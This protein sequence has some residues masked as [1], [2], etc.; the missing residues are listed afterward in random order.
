MSVF[1]AYDGSAGADWVSHYAVRLAARHPSAT[2]RLLHVQDR[3]IGDSDLSVAASRIQEEAARIGVACELS[4]HPL[5]RTVAETLLEVVPAGADSYLICGTRVRSHRSG[6]LTGT[7]S[8]QLLQ[9]GHCHTLAVRVHQ[10]GLL[11]LPRRLLLPVSGHPRG[12]RSG[13]PFLKLLQRDISHLQVLYIEQVGRWRFRSLTHEHAEQLRRPC[14]VYCARIERE[15]KDQLDLR[16][17]EIDTNVV[18]S[19]DAPKEI[20]IAA[21]KTKSRLI[22][23]GA[24]ERNLAQRLYFGDL[25]EHVLH[26]ATCDVA[27]YRGIG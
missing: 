12:F 19:D 25:I 4:R 9:A 24:S 6:L 13:V 3:P 17:T 1:F 14:E 26:D 27:I 7:V 10:P 21:N 15:L 16:A 18:V 20:V 22:Y 23:M 5:R 11:G 2:L 8:E